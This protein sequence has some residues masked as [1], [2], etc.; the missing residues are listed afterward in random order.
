[1][2]ALISFLTHPEP[3]AENGTATDAT[4]LSGSTFSGALARRET[5]DGGEWLHV[6]FRGPLDPPGLGH[7]IAQI[8]LRTNGLDR[9]RILDRTA[10]S[11][12]HLTTEQGPAVHATDFGE[13]LPTRLGGLNVTADAAGH[14][15]LYYKIQRQEDRKPVRR[16]A[17]DSVGPEGAVYDLDYPVLLDTDLLVTA[18]KRT[19]DLGRDYRVLH[20]T[21]WT[22]EGPRPPI[23]N[24]QLVLPSGDPGRPLRIDWRPR[25]YRG[26][27]T[28]TDGGATFDRHAILEWSDGRRTAMGAC[29]VQQVDRGWLMA[30]KDEGKVVIARSADNLVWTDPGP[31][32]GIVGETHGT[33][34][35]DCIIGANLEMSESHYYLYVSGGSEAVIKRTGEPA[36][37]YPT[38]V[39]LWRCPRSADPHVGANWEEYV[40]N[41]VLLRGP[42]MTEYGGA[43]WQ[44]NAVPVRRSAEP[45]PFFLGIFEGAG[46]VAGRSENRAGDLR[47]YQYGG[48]K[49]TWN[50]DAYSQ[51]YA[52]VYDAPDLE[53]AWT[54][55]P[56]PD[57]RYRLRSVATGGY[58]RVGQGDSGPRPV[59]GDR[60]D[61]WELTHAPSGCFLLESGGSAPLSTTQRDGDGPVRLAA[62]GDPYADEWTAAMTPEGDLLIQNRW[63]GEYLTADADRERRVEARTFT[64][65]RDQLWRFDRL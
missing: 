58:L 25:V 48:N 64:G 41:P 52:A 33:W 56:L 59:L 27:S 65:A 1:M 38:A 20:A 5:P 34:Y 24:A 51:T 9:A 23:R 12:V 53:T 26:R 37:D 47:D 63:S 50:V 4:W 3:I 61:T 55:D 44:F 19:L 8:R 54:Q 29:S 16:E 30:V 32:G 2:S 49:V 28:S 21:Y 42:T 14:L 39:G 35:D 10:W 62:P 57:G 22:G 31:A 46:F 60:P 36:D 7:G 11:P 17:P 43:L 45:R 6:F 13:T 18:G 40:R 15:H